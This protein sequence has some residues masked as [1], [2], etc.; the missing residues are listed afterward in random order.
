MLLVHVTPPRPTAAPALVITALV[1]VYIVWG[2]TYLAIRVT[3]EQAPPQLGMGARYVAAGLLLGLVL[4]FRGG[5]RRLRVTRRELAGCAFMGLML[6]VLGNGLVALG[7]S[8][9]TPSG[10]AAVLVALS[11]L[12]IAM[13]RA[14]SGDRPRA[15]SALG[16][17]IGLLGVAWLVLVGRGQGDVPLG[18]SITVLIAST[19]WAFGSWWQPRLT[20]PRDAFVMTVHEMWTGGVMLLVLG[21]LRGERLHV[22][23]YDAHTWLAWSYLVVLGSMV[24]FTAYVWLLA[25]APISLVAT[26]AY[27]NPVVAV[28]LGALL[29]NEPVTSAVLVGSVL[30]VLGVATVITVERPRKVGVD[31]Q[32]VIS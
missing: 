17:L 30:I 14:A 25:N 8:R 13:F 19:C 21:W 20:L 24:A 2:S 12:M 6:P 23:S 3:V 31:E 10:V 27:V 15:W 7:E 28:V 9:G 22:G 16:V 29:L 26:Y 4:S 18:P 11:P 1:V 32:P 5:L